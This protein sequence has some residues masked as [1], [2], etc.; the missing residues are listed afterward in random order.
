M[1]ILLLFL[2]LSIAL[3]AAPPAAKPSPSAVKPAVS[4]SEI[5]QNLRARLARSKLAS[6]NIQ[7]A[8]KSGIATLDG[9]VSVIQHKGV[10]TRMAKSAGAKQVVNRIKISEAARQKAAQQLSGARPVTVKRTP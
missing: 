4:D 3:A 9:Q 5:E 8:V 7:V 1:R 10:A 2:A 6:S